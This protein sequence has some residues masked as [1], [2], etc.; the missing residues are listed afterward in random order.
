[1]MLGFMKNEK[2]FLSDLLSTKIFFSLK[3]NAWI[4]GLALNYRKNRKKCF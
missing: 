3:E 2:I 1:M 4:F